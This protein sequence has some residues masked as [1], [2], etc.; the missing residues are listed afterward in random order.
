MHAFRF[1][2]REH[3]YE[4]AFGH[5]DPIRFIHSNIQSN[6][7]IE[8]NWYIQLIRSIHSINS[9]NPI[10]TFY[11]FDQFTQ[12]TH[13]I[14]FIPKSSIGSFTHSFKHFGSSIQAMNHFIPLSIWFISHI[15]FK[16]SI[17]HSFKHLVH[18]HILSSIQSFIPSGIQSFIHSLIS[19]IQSLLLSKHLVIH[20]FKHWIIHSFK[21]FIHSHNS[22]K[23]L[24]IEHSFKHFIHSLIHSRI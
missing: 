12:S 17:I 24:I 18:S 16:H 14:Q 11:S 2:V 15:F 9:F 1:D 13:S 7:F 4:H 10:D 22:F 3:R 21:H 23:N 5:S 6:S 19:S 8:S 20:S